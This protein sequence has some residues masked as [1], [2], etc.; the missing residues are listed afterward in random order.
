MKEKNRGQSL[1][2]V[3]V[4]LAVVLL[5]VIALVRAVVTAVRSS[6]FAK[7]SAQASSFAQEGMEKVRSYRDQNNWTTF[8][9]NCNNLTAIG[10]SATPAS[11]FTLSVN[12]PDDGSKKKV[13]VR[14]SWTDSAG[15]HKSELISYFTDW[16]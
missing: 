13:M 14:V 16:Q 15:S 1:L 3:I 4:A 2:E 6:D 7:K 12:C 5:V 8:T 10:L 11:P 9:N